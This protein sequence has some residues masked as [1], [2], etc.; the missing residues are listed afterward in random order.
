MAEAVVRRRVVDV[1]V[2]SHPA[3]LESLPPTVK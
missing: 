2:A 1:V 3:D